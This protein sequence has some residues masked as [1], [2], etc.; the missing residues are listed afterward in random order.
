MLKLC[1]LLKLEIIEELL[2]ILSKK[3]DKALC[4]VKEDFGRDQLNIMDL[5]L[6]NSFIQIV[7]GNK[8]HGLSNSTLNDK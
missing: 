8:S 1:Y 2:E 7:L 5:E 4:I 3:V 6:S